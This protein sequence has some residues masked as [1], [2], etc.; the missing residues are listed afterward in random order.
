MLRNDRS[1]PRWP[2]GAK[3]AFTIFDDTDMM[4]LEN[5]RPVYDV[6][7]DLGMRI[8]KSV[9]PVLPDG[10]A[11]TGGATCEDADYRAWVLGL[12]DTGHEIGIHNASDHPSKRPT[13]ER[14]L[15]RFAEIFGHDPRIGADH[16]GNFEAMYW[17]PARLTGIRSRAYALGTRV[18]RPYRQPTEGEV[19]TSEYFWG[20]LLRDR[21]DY[22]RNFTFDDINT[23]RACPDLPYHDPA[24][25]YVNWWFAA[26]QAPTLDALVDLLAP[27]NLDRLEQQGGA[28]IV[29]TH[30]GLRYANDG[31]VDPRFATALE[32]VAERDGW[33]APVSEVLDHIRAERATTTGDRPLST[34]ERSRMENRWIT[35]QV[36]TRAGSELQRLGRRV[37]GLKEPWQ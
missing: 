7:T 31:V 35:D 5:G 4:T 20:D 3:F 21:I 33:F 26:S 25:P 10:P 29:Y 6:I 1:A 13:T 16:V 9:W 24:R 23:L 28:C 27:S 30:L 22:W 12:Q 8:T 36:T 32:R 34:R 37:R 11:R 14:A 2:G 15:D 18:T 17:G 19:P